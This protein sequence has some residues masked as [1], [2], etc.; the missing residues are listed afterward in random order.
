MSESLSN[1]DAI[2]KYLLAASEAAITLFE[3]ELYGHF[4][5]VLYSSIDTAGYLN[6]PKN[7]CSASSATFKPWVEKFFIPHIKEQVTSA[8][9][10]SAR[11]AVLHTFSTVSDLSRSG[12]ARQIQYYQGDPNKPELVNFVEITN[13]IQDG[14][15][16]AVH[17]GNFGSAFG[18]A[19]IDFLPVLIDHCNSCPSTATRLRDVMQ[20]F[21]A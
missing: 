15:H 8:D 19:L 2:S 6:A 7:I 21:P 14:G 20:I 3:K 13:R 17:L 5:I 12:K 4:L 9:L 1:N 18:K 10:W 16:L 11:C